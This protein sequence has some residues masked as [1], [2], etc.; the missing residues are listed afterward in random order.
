M[1]FGVREITDIT[2]KASA[3]GQKLG[4]VV[5]DKYDPILFFDSAKTSTVEG[6]VATVYAQGGRGNPRLLAW[7]GDKTVTFTFEDALMSPHTFAALSGADLFENTAAKI[8]VTQEASLE[9]TGTAGEINVDLTAIVNGS[10]TLSF[11]EDDLL[12]DAEYVK[13]MLLTDEGDI[14]GLLTLGTGLYTPVLDDDVITSLTV[15]G[16]TV[17]LNGAQ[18]GEGTYK[19][20]VDLYLEGASKLLEVSAGKF[21]GYYYVEADTLFRGL[22]GKDYPA[23]FTIPKAKIQSNFTFTMAPTGDPSTFTFTLDAFP[24]TTRFETNKKV[25]F[26][27]D[28][29]DQNS[30]SSF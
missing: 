15:E 27:L 18:V 26:T 16:A 4:S 22:D 24:A 25:L 6:A 1:K 5:Y 29:F 17:F 9:I 19:V 21:A 11:G 13:V 23:Q 3:D 28:V 7:D 2:F 30:T 8:H 12:A 10:D 14:V 20:L